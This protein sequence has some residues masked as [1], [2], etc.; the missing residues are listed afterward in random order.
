MFDVQ[1][2]SLASVS[3]LLCHGSFC[4]PLSTVHTGYSLLLLLTIFSRRIGQLALLW[5]NIIA[6]NPKSFSTQPKGTS[7]DNLVVMYSLSLPLSRR[8]QHLG[9]GILLLD[10]NFHLLSSSQAQSQRL[11]QHSHG[12]I[13]MRIHSFPD[14][15][16][17]SGLLIDHRSP[18]RP[19]LAPVSRFQQVSQDLM[20]HTSILFRSL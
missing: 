4:F 9:K 3:L 2:L 1:M 18:R 20:F 10:Q 11:V 12:V 14:M 19:S 16:C 8:G 13:E 7:F 6:R 5:D 15:C 17:Q